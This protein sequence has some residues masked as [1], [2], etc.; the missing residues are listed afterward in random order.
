MCSMQM[1]IGKRPLPED[2]Y[3]KRFQAVQKQNNAKI[4]INMAMGNTPI[5]ACVTNKG[6]TLA[7]P[8]SHI[9]KFFSRNV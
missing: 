3:I 1:P 4:Q 2:L 7:I 5:S 6:L 9:K 8:S